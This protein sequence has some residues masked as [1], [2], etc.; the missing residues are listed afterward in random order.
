MRRSPAIRTND[1][2]PLSEAELDTVA[3]GLGLSIV[4]SERIALARRLSE[5][6]RASHGPTLGAP[7]DLG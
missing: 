4:E 3:G 1:I 2:H 5:E 6:F 7:L